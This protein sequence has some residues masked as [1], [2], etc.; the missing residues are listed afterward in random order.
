MC[1]CFEA[2]RFAALGTDRVA[3][4]AAIPE[5]GLADSRAA[6]IAAIFRAT[7]ARHAASLAARS[8]AASAARCRRAV[9]TIHEGLVN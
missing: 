4:L 8:A 6:S 7:S 1:S 9:V 3:S 2:F 5:V